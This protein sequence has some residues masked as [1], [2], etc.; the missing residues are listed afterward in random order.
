MR[1]VTKN[2]LARHEFAYLILSHGKSD[3]A[4][5]LMEAIRIGSPRSA[6]LLHHDARSPAPDEKTLQ[7][8]GV[9]LVTPRI[10]PSWG[11]FSLVDSMLN[12]ISFTLENNDF[13]WLVVLSGQDY[14]LRPFT[15]LESE[16]RN[17]SFDAF[18]KATPVSK[19]P[20]GF[21]YYM[22]YWALPKTRYAYRL[23]KSIHKTLSWAQEKLN[24]SNTWLRIQPSPRNSPT[25][26]G[27][28]VFVHPFS[29]T[30]V[31]YK[32]SQWL[33]LSKRAATYLVQFGQERPDIL[34][35]YR[36]TLIPDE[37]YFQTV[38]CNAEDLHVC[39]D[40]R[41]FILWDDTKLAHPVTLTMQHFDAMIS[42]GKDFGRKFDMDVD[43]EVLDRLD[44]V[45]IGPQQATTK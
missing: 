40:H 45:V 34:S 30:F 42:S 16:L 17:S 20:Y 22:R 6:I 25:R 44:E 5:R 41:R 10:S 21:R 32:G 12:S 15:K 43:A 19:G 23:P 27:V 2:R 29:S 39:D 8:I 3:Q 26:L 37:S 33:T 24:Q 36:R 38:L 1:N 9:Q 11:D 18:V 13:D 28:K 4:V 14:P 35:H 7:R 31:C